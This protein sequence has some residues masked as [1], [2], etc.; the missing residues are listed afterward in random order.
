[1]SVVGNYTLNLYCDSRRHSAWETNKPWHDEV[2]Y[3]IGGFGEYIETS[4]SGC[5]K[6]AREQGWL[7]SKDK[8]IAICPNCNKKS[9]YYKENMKS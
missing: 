8:E 2:S 1:M 9:K 5:A 3:Y 4:Y 6:D 7:I